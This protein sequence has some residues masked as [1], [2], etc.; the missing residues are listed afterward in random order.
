MGDLG[1]G[2]SRRHLAEGGACGTRRYRR[3]SDP[4]SAGSQH[5]QPTPTPPPRQGIPSLVGSFD[6]TIGAATA[7]VDAC[8]STVSAALNPQTAT[9][10]PASL[11]HRR[12]GREVGGL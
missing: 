7:P 1:V 8:L 2:T 6:Q 4:R 10:T 3:R 5:I 12:C 11:W 9:R